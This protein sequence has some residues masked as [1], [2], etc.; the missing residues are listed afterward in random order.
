MLIM[1]YKEYS[2]E[3]YKINSSIEICFKTGVASSLKRQSVSFQNFGDLF[4]HQSFSPTS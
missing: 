4:L 1:V 2:E 3:N